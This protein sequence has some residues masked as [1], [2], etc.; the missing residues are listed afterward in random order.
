MKKKELATIDFV[1]HIRVLVKVYSRIKVR[2]W[3]IGIT[4]SIWAIAVI[5]L[6]CAR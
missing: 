1:D 6:L 2:N 3:I 4:N 5:L